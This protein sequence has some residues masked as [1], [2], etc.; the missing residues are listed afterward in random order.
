MNS[1]FK[2]KLG[3]PHLPPMSSDFISSYD[4][5]ITASSFMNVLSCFFF[6]EHLIKEEC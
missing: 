2:N 4:S 3:A 6:D 5:L 1:V